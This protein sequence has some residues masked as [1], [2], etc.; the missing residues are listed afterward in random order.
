M[1]NAETRNHS[2]LLALAASVEKHSE[3]PL[4]QCIVK[5]AEERKFD[6]LRSTDFRLRQGVGI[7]A[8]IDGQRIYAGNAKLME[9]RNVELTDEV[10]QQAD[11][12]FTK[13]GTVIYVA[14]DKLLGFLSLSDTLR[15]TAKD[16]I[17]K[18]HGEKMM[19]GLLT[20]DNRRAAQHIADAAGIQT[21]KYELLPKD[22]VEAVEEWK[23]NG[24][25]VAMVGDGLNDAPALKV[26]D[27]GIAMGKVGSDLT[28][29]AADIVLVGD[30]LSRLPF[31]I[32]LAKKT[33]RTV[34][35]NILLSMSINAVAVVLA[36][37]GLLGP[38]AGALIHN[39]GSVF[40]V[41][42]A[43]LLLNVKE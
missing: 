25:Q 42:N 1:D 17:E 7:S 34:N 31:L 19:T 12:C 36:S 24:R 9:E 28:V 4:A 11:E 30:T 14:D 39:A 37:S 2:S 5:A 41:L 21:V 33:K 43:S 18:L 16:V 38:V 29:N 35:G 10:K 3:H 15:E 27:V 13:G 40:V 22:K 23:R 26:A 20:G 6:L 32:R 8:D